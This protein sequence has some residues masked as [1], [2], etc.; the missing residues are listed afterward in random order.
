MDKKKTYT[1][2]LIALAVAAIAGGGYYF[3]QTR[4]RVKDEPLIDEKPAQPQPVKVL[5]YNPVVPKYISPAVPPKA[6][7][8]SKAGASAYPRGTSVNVRNEPKTTA[9]VLFEVKSG[10]KAGIAT[11]E[12]KQM[13]DGLWYKLQ[14][15]KGAG[16]VRNDVVTLSYV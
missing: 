14:T 1:I 12:S 3:W 15:A 5:P 11:G 13:S 10:I 2:I 9:K 6:A 7:V 16:W 4:E 8:T